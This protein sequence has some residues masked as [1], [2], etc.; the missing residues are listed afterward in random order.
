MIH[1]RMPCKTIVKTNALTVQLFDSIFV[2]ATTSHLVFALQVP[3]QL[4]TYTNIQKQKT[5][6]AFT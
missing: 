4:V 6:V 3:V 1:Q 2:K 5:T